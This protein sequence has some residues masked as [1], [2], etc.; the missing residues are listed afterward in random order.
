[1]NREDL[2]NCLYFIG[3]LI[4]ALSLFFSLENN[5]DKVVKTLALM[6]MFFQLI[7]LHTAAYIIELYQSDKQDAPI[8][9]NFVHVFEMI[10]SVLLLVAVIFAAIN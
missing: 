5:P 10:S 9:R 8:A 7:K 6:A 2:Y 4:V 3:S 1:M